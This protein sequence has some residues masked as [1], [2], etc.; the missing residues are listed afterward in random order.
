MLPVLKI[1]ILCRVLLLAPAFLSLALQA[2]TAQSMP[3]T[4]GERL[5]GGTIQLTSALSGQPAILVA[6]FSRASSAAANEW[7]RTLHNDP[8]FARSTVWY[9][10]Q[11]QR[12]PRLVRPLVRSA[13]RRQTPATWQANTVL[14]TADEIAWRDWF[15]AGTETAP[16]VVALDNNGNVMWR[17][18]GSSPALAEKLKAALPAALH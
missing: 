10:V 7:L 6:S 12:A 17:G 5:S 8:A 14:L 15:H 13:L 4:T 3:A 11:L 9:V 16:S 2:Q 18:T 1:R